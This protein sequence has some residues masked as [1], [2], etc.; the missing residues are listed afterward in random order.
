M[1]LKWKRV[2][3]EEP[4]EDENLMLWNDG[5]PYFV[6][7]LPPR[8][9]QKFGEWESTE[10]ENEDVR[11]GDLYIDLSDLFTADSLDGKVE[12]VEKEGGK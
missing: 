5:H 1:S 4:Q 9:G 2:K 8:R 6:Q 7:Y 12:F 10:Y 11:P 3:D